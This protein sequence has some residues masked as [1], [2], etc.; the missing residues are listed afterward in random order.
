MIQ[1]LRRQAPGLLAGVSLLGLCAGA[2]RAQDAPSLEI[3]GFAQVDY[4]QDFN[5]VNPDWEDALRPSR[6]PTADGQFGDDGQASISVKQSRFG[7]KGSQEIAGKPATFKFEFDMFGVGENAGETHMRLRHF[8]G[9]WGPILVGQT[10]TTFMDVDIFPNTVEYWGPNGMV[11]LRNPMVRYTWLS[12]G[13]EVAVAIEKPGNDIDTGNIRTVDPT[14][15]AAIHGSEEVPDL[16]AHWRYS[17]GWGHVQLAGILRQVRF[18]TDGTVN[19]EPKGHDT[20]WGLN[21]TGNVKVGAK[22][23]LHLGVVYGNGIASYMND[24]GTDLGPKAIPGVTPPIVG[25]PP[26]PPGSLKPEALGLLGLTIYYDHYWNDQWSSSIGWSETRQDNSNFQQ[27]NAY[28]DGQYASA[29][30]LWAPDPKL[31]F[32]VEYI[33]GMRKDFNGAKGE[34]N[35]IQFTGKYSFSSKDFFR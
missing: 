18:E 33:W 14:L 24:G 6:I 9:T 20:G 31:L 28:R 12:G 2:A 35:R 13:H 19:N 10:N 15:G 4:T 22:D 1:L 17:G 3:Y 16:T 34:D 7:I 23:V 32:G 30:I 27:S 21:L 25:G 8:Y 11:F 5:R 26:I 29:N